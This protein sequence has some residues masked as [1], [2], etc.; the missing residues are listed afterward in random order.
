MSSKSRRSIPSTQ[1]RAAVAV[2]GPPLYR[3]CRS[4]AAPIALPLPRYKRVGKKELDTVGGLGRS[5]ARHFFR[6]SRES[7]QG[8]VTRLAPLLVALEH[9]EGFPKRLDHTHIQTRAVLAVQWRN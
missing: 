2:Q 7:L 9:S 4:R 8:F 1:L 6:I 5:V 3:E